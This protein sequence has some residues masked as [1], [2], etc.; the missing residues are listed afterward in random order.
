MKKLT[1]I[2]TVLAF[3]LGI[4]IISCTKQ[5]TETPPA[6]ITATD[7]VLIDYSAAEITGLID[8]YT[9]LNPTAFVDP[10]LKAGTADV[11]TT[12]AGIKLDAC[13]TVSI[14]KTPVLTASAVTGA[15]V[16]FTID[17]GT[18]GCVGKDGKLRKGK[19]VSTFNWVKEGGWSRV[20]AIE[21]TVG[22]V[23]YVGTQT[24]TFSKIAP[25]GHAY[26]TETSKLT[27]TNKEGIK[28]WTSERQRELVEGNG[29]VNPVKTWK[30]TGKTT[31]KNIKGE[32]STYTI[33]SPL[34]NMSNCKGFVAGS[35]ET[36][37]TTGVKTSIKYGDFT[38]NAA[39]KCQDGFT[40]T[41]PGAA[42]QPAVSRFIKY[43]K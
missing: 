35:V 40:V 34:Y 18:A 28:T 36:V 21:L 43:A 1:L 29:G 23:K 31:F 6:I 15:T 33:T 26:Y 38:S 16:A 39:L 10:T 30:V 14:L 5:A 37:S 17:Y 12:I 4:T 24:A 19:I 9:A 11:P 22:D 41:T 42:N 25:F 13:A 3:V 20:S 7:A 32:T 8:D 2:F 27:V